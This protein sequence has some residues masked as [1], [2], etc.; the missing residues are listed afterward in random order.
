M[1]GK[2]SRHLHEIRKAF[3]LFDYHRITEHFRLEGTFAAHLDHLSAQSRADFKIVS[4]CSGLCSAN[5]WTSQRWRIHSLSGPKHS[6]RERFCLI[7][8]WNLP[9]CYLCP[10]PLLLFADASSV[11]RGGGG[12]SGR[13]TPGTVQK[14]TV[15]I[16]LGLVGFDGLS[17]TE[18]SGYAVRQS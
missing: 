16:T 13:R 5:L 15:L 9:C 3:F 14:Y 2:P 4:G 1:H 17:S 10:L 8:N 6:H 11:L 12:E 18:K 7:S